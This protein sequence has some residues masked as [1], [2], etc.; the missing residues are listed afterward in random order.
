MRENDIRPVSVILDEP[1][2]VIS[3]LLHVFAETQLRRRK[4]QFYF[5]LV[6][7]YLKKKLEHRQTETNKVHDPGKNCGLTSVSMSGCFTASSTFCLTA[8]DSVNCLSSSCT[9]SALASVVA[10]GG[11]TLG[12]TRKLTEGWWCC[13]WSSAPFLS[14]SS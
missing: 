1:F 7:F 12:S 14:S 13:C 10:G 9:G 6:T 5:V 2:Y 11:M 3:T 8:S 4:V